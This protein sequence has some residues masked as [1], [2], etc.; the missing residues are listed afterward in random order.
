M[1]IPCGQAVVAR[2]AQAGPRLL[3]NA[4]DGAALAVT[5]LHAVPAGAVRGGLALRAGARF[6]G[7]H[8][9][10]QV[11]A[12][13]ERADLARGTTFPTVVN[14]VGVDGSAVGLRPNGQLKDERDVQG[15]VI[16]SAIPVGAAEGHQN[17][18]DQYRVG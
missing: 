14:D 12:E 13:A 11:V 17:Q 8:A 10:Q 9:A 6:R 3:G 18:G 7:G 2:L 15:G 4:R 16:I 5:Q 1:A